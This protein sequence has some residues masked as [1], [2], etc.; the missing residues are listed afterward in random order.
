LSICILLALFCSISPELCLRVYKPK[1]IVLTLLSGKNA[2]IIGSLKVVFILL[3]Q[4]VRPAL[5]TILF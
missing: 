1:A 2:S 5:T 3:L 4:I